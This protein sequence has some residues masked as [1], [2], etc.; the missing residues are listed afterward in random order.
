MLI[1]FSQMG[2]S[3]TVGAI[4]GGGAFLNTTC[5]YASAAQAVLTGVPKLAHLETILPISFP[6]SKSQLLAKGTNGLNRNPIS[7]AC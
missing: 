1:W 3:R 7:K 4:N 2:I 6:K 5:C